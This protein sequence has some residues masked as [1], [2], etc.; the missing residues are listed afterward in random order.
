MDNR[1][2]QYV[3]EMIADDTS[4][5]KQ[6]KGWDWE[7]IMGKPGK[8]FGDKLINDVGGAVNDLKGLN[9]DW[10]QILG[11]EEIG[12]LEQ[13][14][15]RAL[16]KNRDILKGA[17][18]EGDTS[19]IEHTVEVIAGLGEEFASL[20]SKFDAKSLVRGIGALMKVITPFANEANTIE[21]AFGGVFNRI[22]SNATQSSEKIVN[23]VAKIESATQRAGGAKAK[24]DGLTRQY[25]ELQNF[26]LDY[27]VST[28]SLEQLED[29]MEDVL[30]RWD[31]LESRF[32]GKKR[33]SMFKLEQGKLLKEQQALYEAYGK[34]E[35][36]YQGRSQGEEAKIQKIIQEFENAIAKLKQELEGDTFAQALSKQ[37]SNIEIKLSLDEKEKTKF[38]NELDTFIKGLNKDEVTK[39][40]VNVD[41]VF[42]PN[43]T[44]GDNVKKSINVDNIKAA[45]QDTIKEV[46]EELGKLEIE[47]KKYEGA[48]N[49]TD[50]GK[51]NK[52][53]DRIAELREVKKTNQYLLDN[54][55]DPSVQQALTSTFNSFKA[56]QKVI[57]SKQGAILTKTYDWRRKMIDAMTMDKTDV[58]IQ[59][60]FEKGLE[61]SLG[62]LYN[63]IQQYFE[64]N[65]IELHLNKDAF[66]QEIKDAVENGGVS[67]GSI[68]GGGGTV[69]LDPTSLKTA[70]AEGLIA[71]LTGDFTPSGTSVAATQSSVAKPQKT[72]YLDPNSPYTRHMVEAVKALSEYSRKDGAPA[73]KVRDF[74]ARK[75]IGVDENGKPKSIQ[76]DQYVDASLMDIADMLS[77]LL[78]KYGTTLLD[79]F[80]NLIKDTGKNRVLQD[81]RGDLAELLRTQNIGQKTITEEE[82]RT[83]SIDVFKDYAKKAQMLS[84]FNTKNPK[85]EA[86]K[87]GDFDEIFAMA[88]ENALRIIEETDPRD[89]T[90]MQ[91]AQAYYSNM[92]QKFEALQ[93]VMANEDGVE[94]EAQKERLQAAITEFKEGIKYTYDGLT[95]YVNSF[96]MDVF[97]K[98]AKKP[99]RVAGARALKRVQNALNG[100]ESKISDVRIYKD[101]SAGTLGTT[102]RSQELQMLRGVGGKS[103]LIV[104]YPDR[105]DILNKDTTIEDFAPS[106]KISQKWKDNDSAVEQATNRAN[107]AADLLAT[108]EARVTKFAETEAEI[109]KQIEEKRNQ[110]ASLENEIAK[111]Q[112]TIAELND[113]PRKIAGAR[114]RLT[115]RQAALDEAKRERDVAKERKEIIDN[116]DFSQR[117]AEEA[118]ANAKIARYE[119]WQKNVRNWQKNNTEEYQQVLEELYGQERRSARSGRDAAK[120][121]IEKTQNEIADAN[122]KIRKLQSEIKKFGSTPEREQQLEYVIKNREKY[123]QDLKKYEKEYDTY[124]TQIQQIEAKIL[125]LTDADN[126]AVISDLDVY[127]SQK[128]QKAREKKASLSKDPRIEAEERLTNAEKKYQKA[129]KEY[130]KT[131]S[132]DEV[133]KVIEIDEL[134]QENQEL[135]NKVVQLSTELNQVEEK[136]KEIAQK[137]QLSTTPEQLAVAP[138][139]KEVDDLLAKAEQLGQD[140][141]KSKKEAEELDEKVQKIVNGE[142]YKKPEY[143]IKRTKKDQGVVDRS[144]KINSRL[145]YLTSLANNEVKD[146][147]AIPD[148]LTKPMSK[149]IDA[150]NDSRGIIKLLG[151]DI[152]LDDKDL[153]DEKKIQAL[154]KTFGLNNFNTSE[155]LEAEIQARLSRSSNGE[156]L[157]PIIQEFY[158]KILNGDKNTA[159]KWLQLVF[160]KA[161]EDEA[162]QVAKIKNFAQ[163]DTETVDKLK[164]EVETAD[165]HLKE[166]FQK[167]VE[168]WSDSIKKKIDSL[169][170]GNLSAEEEALTIKEVEELF[171]LIYKARDKY[172]SLFRGGAYWVK[173][174][175]L[176]NRLEEKDYKKRISVEEYDKQRK[177]LEN[178]SNQRLTDELF[179]DNKGLIS[180]RKDYRYS[181]YLSRDE[182]KYNADRDAIHKEIEE[183]LSQREPLLL[184]RQAELLKAIETTAKSGESTEKLE[185]ELKGVNEELARYY[186]YHQ[187]LKS[188]SLT[189]IFADDAEFISKLSKN[190][191]DGA[192]LGYNADLDKAKGMSVDD[193]NSKY[194]SVLDQQQQQIDDDVYD[195]L[196]TKQKDALSNISSLYEK[197]VALDT[198]SKSLK[199]A[200][201]DAEKSGKPVD[202]LKNQ[203]KDVNKQIIEN[204]ESISQTEKLLT[205]VNTLLVDYELNHRRAEDIKLGGKVYN[206]DVETMRVY[207]EE[208]RK[209]IESE[210]VLALARAK[211]EGVEDALSKK[212]SQARKRTN[213]INKER[214]RQADRE[215][216]GNARVQALNYLSSTDRA[217][218]T[219]LEKRATLKRRIRIKE[220]QIDDIENDHK[221]STSWQYKKHQK[222][223]KD[224]LVG[225]YVGSD[226]YHEDRAVGFTKVESEMKSYLDTILPPE[227][228]EKVLY[229]MMQTIGKRGD[230]IDPT[231][232]QESFNR[233]VEDDANYKQYLATREEELNN[234]LNASHRTVDTGDIDFNQVLDDMYKYRDA[235]ETGVDR[236]EAEKQANIDMINSVS[237]DDY[238]PLKQEMQRLKSRVNLN[239]MV[240][241]FED[242]IA[243]PKKTK[244]REAT[245]N[246][247]KSQVLQAG[248]NQT[249]ANRL[250]ESLDQIGDNALKDVRVWSKRFLPEIFLT[251]EDEFR[252]QA[253]QNLISDEERYAKIEIGE[254]QRNYD[255]SKQ[256][257]I[258]AFN[259]ETNKGTD[260]FINKYL[261]DWITTFADDDTFKAQAGDKATD[262]I[263]RF[264][265]LMEENVYNLVS[266][267][268]EGLVIKDGMIGGINVR[269]EVRKMLLNELEILEGKQPDIDSNIA[270]I[271]AQRKAAMKYGGIGYNEVIDD[272]ILEEQAILESKLTA[273]KAKQ[274]ELVEQIAHLEQIG[275]SEEELGRLNKALDETNNSIARL[276][277]QVDNRDVLMALRQEARTEEEAERKFTPEQQI[278]WYTNKLE[279]ARAN[280]ESADSAV[281]KQ[282]EEQV[283]RYTEMLGRLEAKMTAEEAERRKD[284]SL[285]GVLTKALRDA[286][287]GKGGFA[288]DATGIASEVTLTE[289]LQILT[290]LVEAFGGKVVR[291]PEMEA[292]LARMR[293]LEAKRG[294]ATESS[295]KSSNAS[296]TDK[297]TD[298]NKT[299]SLWKEINAAA[300][301]EYEE[302]TKDGAQLSDVI[303]KIIEE[304]KPLK[305]GSR[306]R[307][308][309]QVALQKAISD[310]QN[311]N[312]DNAGIDYTTNKKGEKYHSNKDIAKYLGIGD[313]INLKMTKAQV[314][315]LSGF[316]ESKKAPQAENI[317]DELLFVSNTSDMF[318]SL[319]NAI[320]LC[321]QG[322]DGLNSTLVITNGQ[323]ATNSS[324]PMADAPQADKIT[325]AAQ[326][327]L[328]Q[329]LTLGKFRMPLQNTEGMSFKDFLI[330]VHKYFEQ[331]NNRQMT[332]R[333]MTFA[334][335]VDKAT[336]KQIISTISGTVFGTYGHGNGMTYGVGEQPFHSH[337]KNDLFSKADLRAFDDDDSFG[338]FLPDY[339]YLTVSGMK[340]L[341]D[342]KL[343]EIYKILHPTG[344]NS[345]RRL[346]GDAFVSAM[347]FPGIQ[348][349]LKN[350]GV[351]VQ[352]YS[353]DAD[354]NI[355]DFNASVSDEI[356]NIYNDVKQILVKANQTRTPIEPGSQED[357]FGK[358]AAE[359][360]RN[361][362][363]YARLSKNNSGLW[364]IPMSPKAVENHIPIDFD[365]IGA[366]QEMSDKGLDLTRMLEDLRTLVD[367]MPDTD[368]TKIMREFFSQVDGGAIS[369]NLIN[370]PEMRNVIKYILGESVAL[371]NDERSDDVLR[372]YGYARDLTDKS[373]L[374]DVQKGDI[375]SLTESLGIELPK[376]IEDVSRLLDNIIGEYKDALNESANNNNDEAIRAFKEK[377]DNILRALFSKSNN[378]YKTLDNIDLGNVSKDKT[379]SRIAGL[380]GIEVKPEMPPEA[381]KKEAEKNAEENP[382]EVAV[383]PKLDSNKKEIVAGTN[384]NDLK[385]GQKKAYA[386]YIG[387][388]VGNYSP[389]DA[390][391]SN[392]ETLKE[393]VKELQGI[394]ST[395]AEDS[396]EYLKAMVEMSRLIS[397]WRNVVKKTQPKMKDNAEWI[398]YLTKGKGKLFDKAEDVPLGGIT[399][400]SKVTLKQTAMNLG[401]K[402]SEDAK[403][404][405]FVAK[406]SAENARKEADAKEREEKAEEKIKQNKSKQNDSKDAES[407]ERKADAKEREAVA[408]EKIS[409]EQK[410]TSETPS[411]WTKAE[412]E[413]YD[414][415]AKETK[416]YKPQVVFDGEGTFGGLALDSTLQDILTAIRKIQTEGIKKGGSASSARKNKNKTEADLIK[417]RALSQDAT[418]RGLAAGRGDLYDKY[419]AEVDALNKAVDAANKAKKN[420]QRVDM[421]AVKAAAEKVSAL[422]RNILRDTASWDYIVDQSDVV[423]DFSLPDGQKMTQAIMENAAKQTFDPKKEKYDFLSF[424]DDTLTY[425]LTDIEGK[426]RR[427]TMVWN[428]F[429]QQLAITSDKS[430]GLGGLAKDVDNLKSKF[431]DAQEVGYLGKDDENLKAFI[432]QLEKID[433]MVDKK[434]AFDNVEAERK[435]AIALGDRVKKTVAKNKR[436]YTGTTEINA[437]ERQRTDMLMHGVLDDEDVA[438]VKQYNVAYQE[439]INKHQEFKTAGT[440]YDPENQ[441]TLQRMAIGVKDLGRALVVAKKDANDLEDLVNRSGT[442]RGKPIGNMQEISAE[443]AENL[444]SSMRAYLKTLNLGNIENVKFDNVHQRLTGSLRL[445]NKAVA[446]LEM[447]YNDVTKSLYLYQKQERESLTGFPAFMRGFQGKINSILQYTASITSIYRIWGEIRRGIQYIREIDS[448]LTELKKVTDETEKTYDNFLDTAA[449]TAD[450]V[451]STIKEVVSSTADWA[452]LGYSLEDAHQLAES[453]SILLNV[454]EFQSIEDATSALT[455]TLQAFGYT[456]DQSMNVVDVLNEVGNNFAISSDG[457]ATALQDSASSLMAANNS[458]E[459]AVALIAAANRVVQDPNSVGA[460]L[461][462]ISLRLRGT[463]AKELEEAGE[464]S[465]G[466]ITSKSKLRSKI[467]GLSG[468]D[469][470]TDTGAY[471]STYDILLEISKVWEDMSDINQAALLEI[472]AGKTRS[473]TA[474]AILSNTKDLEEAYVQALE[475]E[476]SALEENEKYLDSIQGKIDLFTNAVQTMWSNTLDSSVV[477][478]FVDL[479]TA[480]I[481]IV[482]KLGLINSILLAIGISKFIPWILKLTTHTSTFGSALASILKPLVQLKG[483]GQT[484][485]QVFAQVAAGAMNASG[486]VATF[487][488]Y[489]K[490]AGAVLKAFIS[491]P[492]GWF[493]IFAL[494]VGAVVAI[495]DAVTDSAAELAEE[496]SNLKS[497]LSATESEIKTLNSELET[498]RERIA[499]LE[500]LPSLSF[501]EQEELNKLKAQNEE[502]ER[503]LKIQ[504]MLANSQKQEIITTAKEYIDKA[505]DS[506]DLDKAYYIDNNGVIHKD[507]FWHSGEDTKD[508][509]DQAIE[510]YG[511]YAEIENSRKNILANLD[512]YKSGQDVDYETWKNMH[513]A[514]YGFEE[515]SITE[516]DYYNYVQKNLD[517]DYLK[518]NLMS[519]D[520]SQ[521]I[522]DIAEGINMVLSDESFKGL[523]YGMSEEINAFLDELYTYGLKFEQA[524]GKY[525]KS[526]A[527]SALFDDTSTERMQ[528]LGKTIQEIA[529]NEALPDADKE[530]QIRKKISDALN[531]NS[532]AYNRLKIT[533]E[534]LGVTAQ[535][536]ADYFLLETGAFDSSTIE[537]VTTQYAEALNVMK[538]LKNIGSD[539]T[540]TIGEE[541]FNWDE[542]FTTNDEGEFEARADKFGEI[543]KGMDE[544]CRNTFMSMAE[545]VKNG[546]LTWEQAI[547][548]FSHSG[549]LAG[550]K[551]IEAQIV[552]LNN[553]Q[554]KN[555][556]DDISGVIDTFSEF[557]TALEDVASSME[558]LNTAQT[559]MNN[560]GRISVKTALEIM[561]STDQWNEILE[562]ENGNI[563]LV[564]D[565]TKVLVEDKLALI[566][567]NLQN[568]LSTV[569]EQLAMIDATNASADHAETIE[570]STNLAVRELA[571]NMAYLTEMMKAYTKA[572][573]GET[574]EWATIEQNAIDAKNAALEATNYKKHSAEKIGKADLEKRE[575]E[576]EAQLEMLEGIDTGSEFKNYYDYDKTPGDKYD[577]SASDKFQK[578][579]DY[580]ENRIGANQARYEQIQSEI[581]LLESQGKRAGTEYFKEQIE[582]EEQ[583]RSLLEQ[584]KAEAEAFLGAF[585][586]GS[587]EWWEVANTLNDIEGEL[588]D[589]TASI[590]ELG[591][592]MAQIHW[593]NLE[594]FGNR[595]SNLHSELSDVRDLL[596]SEDMFNDEGEWTEAGVATLGS[597]IQE[598]EMYK[599]ELIEIED[600]LNAFSRGYKGNEDDFKA[601]WGLDSEQEY[602]DKLTELTEKQREYTKGIHDSEQSVVEMYENQIDAIEDYTSELVDAYND[603]IDVVKEALDAERELYEFKKDIQEQTKDITELERKIAALSGSDNAADIAER[604][605]LQAELNDAKSNLDDTY[606]DH[607][608][609]TQQTALDEEA[610]A[611]EESM[612]NYIEKLRVTLDEAKLDMDTFMASVNE[613]IILNAQTI[614]DK[615]NEVNPYMSSALTQPWKDAAAEVAKFGGAEGA[616]SAMNNWIKEDG[617]FGKFKSEATK[618]LQSPW[619]AGQTALNS[620][621]SAVNTQMAKVSEA[622]KSNVVNAKQQLESLYQ[623]IKDTEQRATNI[624][625]GGGGNDTGGSNTVAKIGTALGVSNVASGGTT[626][627]VNGVSYTQVGGVYYK[628]DDVWYDKTTKTYNVYKGS[629]A[630][631]INNSKASSQFAKNEGLVGPREGQTYKTPDAVIAQDDITGLY[632]V[633]WSGTGTGA[634][635]SYWIK[636][637][638]QKNANKIKDA[639]TSKKGWTPAHNYN[640]YMKKYAKGTTGTTKDEW[641][642]TDEPWLGDE[643]VLVPTAEGN[644][645]Y[646]RKGTGVV[647]A[648]LTENLMEWGKLNPDM[649]SVNNGMSNLNVISNA[650]NKP[651]FNLTFDALVKAEKI[652]EDTLPTLKKFVTQE[653]NNLV[654][655]MNYA[656]KG[657]AR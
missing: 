559:Q 458:Y 588:D 234:I 117:D 165:T 473:N 40:K 544:D 274:K 491:T 509:L 392:P 527:I 222:V 471:K 508:V 54:A 253:R 347:E 460:A 314:E 631:S 207:N 209:A 515:L 581:D 74:F 590:Q 623:Q 355:S 249:E 602:Y 338:L 335:D 334:L 584:Q 397:T 212:R 72:V 48:E 563:T 329:A 625:V 375:G 261:S 289:I 583:R 233:I 480:I 442:Y 235:L 176:K 630:Y 204:N 444:E 428:D 430:S 434:D 593:D 247:L 203:L 398:A 348:N 395:S 140:I 362:A 379:I 96:E 492:L 645:S 8:G 189:E 71:A 123:L 6:M 541:A 657:Y 153:T 113:N 494:A 65:E 525:V 51:Y 293:E 127:A 52:I 521:E 323:I 389:S 353:F 611:Y 21:K 4:L 632:Y 459:E 237:E 69:N 44:L 349:Q 275:D 95:K 510:K 597:Y 414:T 331:T 255:R 333:E 447:R 244:S 135:E 305:E 639:L 206:A 577:D 259:R 540:F 76:I 382:P 174:S 91:R 42:N 134:K 330:D 456:A 603:Y 352:R 277:M 607:A 443:E 413:E 561:Q 435:K 498:T 366:M 363:D 441:K 214:E 239:A 159:L 489:L 25:K 490:G 537:G 196:N 267:Y 649:M 616:L 101:I 193:L 307:V 315:K 56:V 200:I 477:K 500:A 529:D 569:R 306:E 535:D 599:N 266:S 115:N 542:F 49:T 47:Q 124:A 464:D 75:T 192:L 16:S 551:V 454:S 634:T 351:D 210:Q 81:F 394:M 571:G 28:L 105:T 539:G 55:E 184:T 199:D 408:E 136:Q 463:S 370:T 486:G 3:I 70:I 401:T 62:N 387:R 436:L 572:A 506:E 403:N 142:N 411:G 337:P 64:E 533:Q 605:K 594:E 256:G 77:Q 628:T 17:I 46:D 380:Y 419:T 342:S 536:I 365:T 185:A 170:K 548:S 68:G 85:W 175:E 538:E 350:L 423:T 626:K 139:S 391:F 194:Y 556:K 438:Q 226:Q 592:A 566:K 452:R 146:D 2:L 416:G 53:T 641:A 58:N 368:A 565:A 606:Y 656:L 297:K 470:L 230:K 655:Q 617:Y 41:W 241:G 468:V 57:E 10:A 516:D 528:A 164:P 642:I 22:N 622:V 547:K 100:D 598:I 478:G 421:Q 9:I 550:L 503:S 269:E 609:D 618:A 638:T 251:T 190:L 493:T 520:W 63:F 144:N 327:I 180:Q 453:T 455:S 231:K 121:N 376:T 482:D 369:K 169:S 578:A 61:A 138:Q 322:F 596:S 202:D 296:S 130:E 83:Q 530:I 221:Y 357:E 66:I 524:Q 412:K 432:A 313:D 303:K 12:H 513:L 374:I 511:F 285:V 181:S 487:G 128:L 388:S 248:G 79:D 440:L 514:A 402:I 619:S 580:W 213:A 295:T 310:F 472:L 651:E 558:L 512:S 34:F 409:E 302:A 265:S 568:A 33:S 381:V 383:K 429:N 450:K 437:V 281:R 80:N 534:E 485:S 217:Y 107:K 137:K 646:M 316:A 300:K 378:V 469:I 405:L 20:G 270:H 268:A 82:R 385:S 591:D 243:D 240:A 132:S 601:T 11:T 475:A 156:T 232:L 122:W 519:A 393:K 400:R 648:D 341:D 557:S 465:D 610:Q 60:G 158:N 284:S 488:S 143:D 118:D 325:D 35:P 484:L 564:G 288:L 496:L 24:L 420:K 570:E 178:E 290:G 294:T 263:S 555:I 157:N 67:V 186:Q 501:V 218:Q 37:L 166:T 145:R 19:K 73:A 38:K 652:T 102:R 479:G 532:D 635:R 30:K 252:E 114:K 301:K 131:I 576:L 462:T 336:G 152:D 346:F 372:K 545:S 446:D 93:T 604:R 621:A 304:I 260:S 560:S 332:P 160:D 439:L 495:V 567:A 340:G 615:Y 643:L 476:G 224:R 523:S 1:K 426:V 586:E 257:V 427:V 283:A 211:G 358:K 197:R 99:Y 32:Q 286:F 629:S 585:K 466:A 155:D 299:N 554:F 517:L 291:D 154:S 89:K 417:D 227:A 502:L 216:A 29:K 526:D 23:M 312:K 271:E 110:K 396:E 483:T 112:E 624:P 111:N 328:Q 504:E 406:E 151:T 518:E 637:D 467:K 39:A 613:S 168:E 373:R 320:R 171:D 543:L 246:Y 187:L 242:V 552:E 608:K 126:E 116:S 201:S 627:T 644:L 415:L 507:N 161:R 182:D 120:S 384:I 14:L 172:F 449:K 326:T 390:I 163:K 278:A 653:I 5:R 654:K 418:V 198:Q 562:I 258:S 103:D 26:K 254:L 481:K 546:E 474:A 445:S 575:D 319:Y 364:T 150:L 522:T 229:Q 425:Q 448:A 45:I 88:K 50:K 104:P 650:V 94:G 78:E 223:I 433:D 360:I 162:N 431:E 36:Y 582:L 7:D 345:L 579:M 359:I 399:S 574:V 133:K 208:T 451:G 15:T 287:G 280:L 404:E 620:F 188:S 612:N 531:S 321:K 311:K 177:A 553:T 109:E 220:S 371:V 595:V 343:D 499:E 86:P 339:S 106:E 262:I 13:A 600:E 461:R 589:V 318:K 367:A 205:S 386:G 647:P 98:G 167:R 354:G 147:D 183:K 344:E 324:A 457:I 279:V 84:V 18:A 361:S 141:E 377:Y 276:Q 108:S 282:A 587:D 308:I 410:V 292:K 573:Q 272:D 149:V 148:N 27:D 225:D 424:D 92:V 264:K 119:S 317:T 191:Y 97:V 633:S 250:A 245:I 90:G 407:A 43:E 195:K 238:K 614:L 228:V 298:K 636:A 31:N 59:L 549:S 505:W 497:E 87:A 129:Q 173:Q 422:T 356:A 309:K 125:G 179:G 640:G 273:E 236:I 219:A 215:A